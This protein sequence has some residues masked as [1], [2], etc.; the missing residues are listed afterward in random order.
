VL[1]ESIQISRAND[2]ILLAELLIF[3]LML[4]N[5][6]HDCWPMARARRPDSG[7][8]RAKGGGHRSL[9]FT[10]GCAVA[11]CVALDIR[12]MALTITA[13]VGTAALLLLL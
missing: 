7:Q 4:G 12:P 11:R 10:I 5:A 3:G 2:R 13:T 1:R 8:Q 6:V 9:A